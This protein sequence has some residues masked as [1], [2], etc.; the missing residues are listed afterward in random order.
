M[1]DKQKVLMWSA[2][3]HSTALGILLHETG[4]D[5]IVAHQMRYYDS[6]AGIS[7]KT[8]KQMKAFKWYK[9]WFEKNGHDVVVFTQAKDYTDYIFESYDGKYE[10]LRKLDIYG[11]QRTQR[12]GCCL[13]GS[14]ASGI[15]GCWTDKT[16]LYFGSPFR[17]NI[18]REVNTS[19]GQF[20]WYGR[21]PFRTAGYTTEKIAKIYEKY[22]MP[23]PPQ[24]YGLGCWFC[25]HITN[26]EMDDLKA[27]APEYYNLHKCNLLNW[28]KA[29]IDNKVYQ[30]DNYM[31]TLT[32]YNFGKME[33][34]SFKEHP[35]INGKMKYGE[36]FEEKLPDLDSKFDEP[37]V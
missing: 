20:K 5:F 25:P 4:N 11:T 27:S 36:F 28:N 3:Y 21:F 16:E 31:K 6:I 19:T 2:G 35:W 9:E 32:D 37:P 23:V 1:S 18:R 15:H 33:Y 13:C 26:T 10:V 8:P 30:E 7:D 17:L 24:R 14:K 22:N 12:N 34:A 29:Y